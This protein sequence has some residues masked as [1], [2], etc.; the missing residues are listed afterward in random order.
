M[1]SKVEDDHSPPHMVQVTDFLLDRRE[2][3]N[4][5]YAE[6]CEATDHELPQFWEVERFSSGP[7]Y[8][9]HPVVGTTWHDALAFCRWRGMRLPTEAEWEYAAKG[10]LLGKKF[11]W[12][13]KIDPENANYHPSDGTVAVGS[14]PPNDYGLFDMAGNVGEWVADWYD[15]GYY[16]ESP[17]EDPKGPEKGKY[18]SVRGGG[19]RSGPYCNRVDRRLGLLPT[20]VDIYVGFRCAA[21]APK[22]IATSAAR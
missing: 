6:F 13:D 20:W 22:P 10:G 4:A 12:G 15:P 3:T 9:D 5:Q 18:K 11:P 17:V 2:V 16:A 7:D 1:G 19:W 21:D 14:F 8:P